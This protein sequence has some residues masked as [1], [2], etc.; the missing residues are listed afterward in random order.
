[1]QNFNSNFNT[2]IDL[3]NYKSGIYLI[4]IKQ[5]DKEFLNKV[6]VIK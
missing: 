5:G 2:N 4:K 6:S 1:M 3:T